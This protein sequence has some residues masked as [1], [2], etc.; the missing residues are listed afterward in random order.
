MWAHWTVSGK[1]VAAARDPHLTAAMKQMG[2]AV[3]EEQVLDGLLEDLRMLYDK[4]Q[5][6]LRGRR[7]LV[8]PDAQARPRGSYVRRVTFNS[9]S[10]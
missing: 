9:N 1:P 10:G 8:H 6:W 3:H 5:G 4:A 2:K 7:S